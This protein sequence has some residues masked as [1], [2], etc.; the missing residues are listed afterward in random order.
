MATPRSSRARSWPS[1][2]E[3]F[4]DFNGPGTLRTHRPALGK[5]SN[6]HP[7]RNTWPGR[8]PTSPAEED[9]RGATPEHA[10]SFVDQ[11]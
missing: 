10:G 11:S 9:A 1:T 2:D 6:S 5:T 7:L 8:R 4:K 3:R